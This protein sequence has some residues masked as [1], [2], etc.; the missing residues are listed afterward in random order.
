MTYIG[1]ADLHLFFIKRNKFRNTLKNN[2]AYFSRFFKPLPASPFLR[3]GEIGENQQTLLMN[4]GTMP[5]TP[6]A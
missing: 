2:L 4:T 1:S 5:N 3:G 6:N